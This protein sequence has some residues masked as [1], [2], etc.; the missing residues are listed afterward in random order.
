M[1]PDNS[2]SAGSGWLEISNLHSPEL[3]VAQFSVRTGEIW[4][5]L[6]Q[7]DS[8]VSTLLSV[9]SRKD[10]GASVTS[11][12]FPEDLR[13]VSFSAQQQR[14]EYELRNDDS[15]YL[16][17]LDP[18]TLAREFV[19]DYRGTLDLV[20]LFKLDHLLDTGYRQLSSGESRKLLMVE[21]ITSGSRHL[22]FENP[23]DGLDVLSVKEFNQII[24]TLR[25]DGFNIILFISDPT[26]IPAWCTHLLW[27]EGGTIRDS[28]PVSQLRDRVMQTADDHTSY[29]HGEPLKPTTG[30]PSGGDE[31]VRLVQGSASYGSRI[32]FQQLDLV[33]RE[34]DHTL[35]TGPNGVGKS[36][37]LSVITG[38]HH[39][40]YSNELY[41][42]GRKRGS[43][44]SIWQI[45]EQMGIVSPALHRNHYIPGNVRQVI[46]S[47]FFD[48]IGL[49]QKPTRAQYEH[50]SIWLSN[51]RLEDQAATPFRRLSFGL[52]RLALIA[53]AMVKMPR[54][55]I[56]DEPT[57]G[58]DAPNRQRLL[59]FLET[60]AATAPSTILYV[61]HRQD[62]YQSFFT[63]HVEM[64]MQ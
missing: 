42:F 7:N 12:S 33:I 26:D 62:E 41:L 18:G 1:R 49:Y 27:I 9:L 16:D 3:S 63:Q 48:S 10:N 58:L 34:G 4:C 57:Q 38:D 40:C 61:S 35:I 24:E 53:R 36:T 23:Y 50:A 17:R 28:G 22:V 45:K 11:A 29:F 15:D 37:L 5:V 54:L 2:S 52:Q 39:S 30:E 55:L 59:H 60:V 14:Y 21:A 6:G 64:K 25:D 19:G 44:E 31:L 51:I 47:G 43:G 32:I 13:L 8:G 20:G 56:L 46:L